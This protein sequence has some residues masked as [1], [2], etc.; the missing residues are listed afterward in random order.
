[1]PRCIAV[2]QKKISTSDIFE[3][4]IAR[5]LE[6]KG[7]NQNGTP[8]HVRI[9]SACSLEI[10]LIGWIQVNITK[11]VA[12]EFKVLHWSGTGE[13]QNIQCS[14]WFRKA[15]KKYRNSIKATVNV[16]SGFCYWCE[17]NTCWRQ[18][19]AQEIP[20]FH[21]AKHKNFSKENL[22]N[23]MGLQHFLFTGIRMI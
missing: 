2:T 5:D 20:S 13:F 12:W 16:S 11:K 10:S 14:L 8:L 7:E 1:M 18:P 6:E 21:K 22:K 9:Y 4:E 17:L 3:S 23:M 19:A 15:L